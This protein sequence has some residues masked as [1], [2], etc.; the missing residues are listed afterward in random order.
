ML[1]KTKSSAQYDG[2][3]NVI[4]TCFENFQEGVTYDTLL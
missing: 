1:D 3:L 2:L 4:L